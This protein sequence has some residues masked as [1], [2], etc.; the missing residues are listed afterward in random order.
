M[1]K[2]HRR[3]GLEG[4]APIMDRKPSAA[5]AAFAALLTVTFVGIAYHQ[6][7]GSLYPTSPANA[8]EINVI[9]D[10]YE[11]CVLVPL[12]LLAIWATRRGRTWGPLLIIGV[13]VHFAYNYAMAIMGR[14]N[15]W[16][17]VW[18]AKFTLAALTIGLT[19]SHLPTGRGLAGRTRSAIAIY[20]S[21]VTVIFS[22][23]MG[24]RL[25]ASA[26]GQFVDMTMQQ[27][28]AVDWGE[29]ILRDPVVFFALVIPM[30]LAAIVGGARRTEWGGRAVA[31]MCAF[32]AGMVSV[33]LFTGP[34]VKAVQTRTV[35]G[36]MLIISTVMILAAAPAIWFLI[37]L[38]KDQRST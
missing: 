6:L 24:Q 35:P 34:L 17:F 36:P 12:G 26:T 23:L 32:V 11:A 33:I 16:I 9:G 22:R 21:I 38:D 37:R 3:I 28:G 25:V 2:Q 7:S 18:I 4:V 8:Y 20:L 14:Q 29:S 19:W 1:L 15:L 31:V 27:I 10:I 13:S 5:L 30:A